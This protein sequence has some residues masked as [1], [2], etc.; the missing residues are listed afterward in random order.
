MSSAPA[1]TNPAILQYT[2]RN[3][4]TNTFICVL[5]HADATST[6]DERTHITVQAPDGDYASVPQQPGTDIE[7]AGRE[8]KLLLA[9][10]ALKRG[11][12]ACFNELGWTS[13][14][15]L[16][17]R[18]KEAVLRELFAPGVGA[19]FTVCRMPVG[20]NDFSL[21]WYSYDEVPGDFGL[22][23][24]SIARDLETLVPFIK[25]A[26]QHQPDLKLWA[27]PWSPP[28][29]MKYNRHYA[30][31]LPEPGMPP[32]GLK[33]DQVVKRGTDQFIQEDRYFNAYAAYVGRFIQE[34]ARQGIPIGV[35]MPQ[36]EFNS[37]QPFPSCVWTAEGLARFVAFL[38]PEAQKLNVDVFFGTMERPDETLVEVSLRDPKAGLYVKGA[39][40]QWAGRGAIPFIHRRYPELM[41]YQTEQECGDGKNDW[42]YCRYAWTLM[43]HY[44]NHGASVYDYWNISLKQGGVG[45]W[46]WAQNS[47]VTVD[48]EAKTFRYNFEYYLLKHL[49]HFVQPGAKRLEIQGWTGYDNLLAF[50]N[51]DR[52]VVIM[53]QNELCQEL[54]VRVRAGDQVIAAALEADSF[55]TFVVR[56]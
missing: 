2:R 31:R 25:G 50:A 9:D 30:G 26:L 22:E 52:S 42:R 37:T 56:A 34:Y 3:P 8:A 24:F 51:P 14:S 47:L 39:G 36:N 48:T 18:D 45:R 12:G 41:L 28:T 15:A 11:F 21:D 54:P 49:S 43:K 23:H 1:P 33:P 16:D 4:E 19:I 53:M 6:T 5:R 17:P 46:G 27:S 7:I 44:L 35:V 55:N 32:N 10:F 20:A 38:G 40:F 13:L 29:W